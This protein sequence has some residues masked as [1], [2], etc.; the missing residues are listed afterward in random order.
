LK[1]EDPEENKRA[2]GEMEIKTTVKKLN[3]NRNK[4]D[5]GN[6]MPMQMKTTLKIS[7]RGNHL[8]RH[9]RP[10]ATTRGN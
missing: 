2:S 9:R 6:E 3:G 1:N 8:H 10:T 4:N 5:N 7:H